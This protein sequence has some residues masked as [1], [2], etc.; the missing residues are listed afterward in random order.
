M[1]II[2]H[3]TNDNETQH[4]MNIMHNPLD[5]VRCTR[6]YR[7]QNSGHLS[8]GRLINSIK[9]PQSTL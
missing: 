5:D 7:L 8:T 1:G 2:Q 4:R 9:T 6:L 3:Y